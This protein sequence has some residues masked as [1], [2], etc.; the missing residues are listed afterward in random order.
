MLALLA[1]DAV[2]VL[3][4]RDRRKAPQGPPSSVAAGRAAADGGLV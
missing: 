3:V 4:L 2:V 1:L